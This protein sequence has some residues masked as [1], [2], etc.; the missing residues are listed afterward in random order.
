[1]EKAMHGRNGQHAATCRTETPVNPRSNVTAKARHTKEEEDKIMPQDTL[2]CTTATNTT[3]AN[4]FKFPKTEPQP[5]PGHEVGF[6]IDE[7]TKFVENANNNRAC[8]EI[9]GM[10]GDEARIALN[11]RGYSDALCE[12]VLV[13]ANKVAL[14]FW[15]EGYD[16]MELA[17]DYAMRFICNNLNKFD[18]EK[19][20]ANGE[21]MM[22]GWFVEYTIQQMYTR[23]REQN[24]QDATCGG[25]TEMPRLSNRIPGDSHVLSKIKM[26]IR[27]TERESGQRM[28]DFTLADAEEMIVKG[29]AHIGCGKGQKAHGVSSVEFLAKKGREYIEKV[30]TENNDPLVASFDNM[31]AEG[32]EMRLGKAETPEAVVIRNMS[33]SLTHEERVAVAHEADKMVK[34]ISQETPKWQSKIVR[35]FEAALQGDREN[36]NEFSPIAIAKRIGCGKTAVIDLQKRLCQLFSAA[37]IDIDFTIV[38]G[39]KLELFFKY[40]IRKLKTNHNAA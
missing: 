40:V 6:S 8:A 23:E 20:S 35:Y 28:T 34:V 19:R 38:E 9:I 17:P 21:Q 4:T 33:S 3:A 29:Y 39:D 37:D 7:I 18:P 11:D 25:I 22:F 16:P 31:I 10:L 14:K 2:N 26:Y 5:A 24:I 27:D 13:K 12:F 32:Q 36:G 1:M 15:G 30:L